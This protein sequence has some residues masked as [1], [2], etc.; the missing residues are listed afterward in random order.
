MIR[1]FTFV[2]MLLAAASGLYLY[3]AKQQGRVLDRKIR[4]VREQI[5]QTRQHAEVLRAEYMQLQDPTRLAELVA[6]HLTELRPTQPTQWASLA[7][8]DKR[9]PPV[10]GPTQEPSPLEPGAPAVEVQAPPILEAAPEPAAEPASAKVLAAMPLPLPPE[11]PPPPVV[12]VAAVAASP[13]PAA[14]PPP[15]P[16]P[17]PP[18]AAPVVAAALALGPPPPRPHP[19]PA[20][21]ALP[22]APAPHAAAPGMVTLARE[23]APVARPVPHSAWVYEAPPTRNGRAASTPTWQAS[24]QPTPLVSVVP[25]A[26]RQEVVAAPPPRPVVASALGMARTL[27][28]PP[29]AAAGGATP[30][31]QG[32]SAGGAAQ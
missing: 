5:D 8:L 20:P 1:P 15:Q 14:A 4:A 2:C 6:E 29:A 17:L 26:A 28:P 22:H 30:L 24:G 31:Y 16:R 32:Q 21:V 25:A 9:L 13:A 18:R 12:P 23:P 3:Q 27:A 11:P 7:D 10:G 19:V